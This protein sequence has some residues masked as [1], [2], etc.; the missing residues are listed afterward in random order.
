MDTAIVSNIFEPALAST[1][2]RPFARLFASTPSA[3]ANR[4]EG[5]APSDHHGRVALRAFCQWLENAAD[6]LEDG[7]VGLRALGH[8]QRG[9]GGVVELGAASAETLRDALVFLAANARLLNEA[10]DFQLWV[11]GE[12][13]SFELRSRLAL[14][15]PLRDFQCGLVLFAI[16]KWLGD[17]TDFQVWFADDEPRHGAL[18]RSLFAPSRVRFEAPCDAIVF[19]AACLSRRSLRAEPTLHAVLS[20]YAQHLAVEQNEDRRIVLRVREELFN[21]LPSGSGDAR[22]ISRRMGMSRRTLSRHLARE[23]MNFRQLLEQV[24]HQ[25][26]LRYLETTD[27]ELSRVAGLLGYTEATSFCRAFYRWHGQS[28]M[29][30]RRACRSER[31]AFTA[32]AS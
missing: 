9:M 13:A 2:V 10:A 15:R 1:L 22:E 30:Y 27:F 20:S 4:I 12:F 17:T 3:Q 7:S 32:W 6:L 31:P 8:L 21:L 28:P 24:R 5:L 18:H 23:G 16:R 26:A 11:D 25:R 14:P 19:N 29:T